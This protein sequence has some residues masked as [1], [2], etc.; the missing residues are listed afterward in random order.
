MLPNRPATLNF[1]LGEAAEMIRDSARD[2]AENDIAP[3]AAEIDRD[4]RFPRDLWP[5]MGALGL[6]G[7]TAPEEYGGLGL[8]YTLATVIFGGLTPWVAQ[9][10]VERTGMPAAPGVNVR[11]AF[12]PSAAE[13]SSAA[14]TLP[15]G[16]Y[17]V[18]AGSSVLTNSPAGPPAGV[19]VES[20]T[21]WPAPPLNEKKSTSAAPATCPSAAAR[22]SSGLA[23]A[24]DSLARSSSVALIAAC[25]T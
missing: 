4:N 16:S 15:A 12:R 18:S 11:N 25:S 8:G 17:T 14:T 20:V 13:L 2:Y 24:A 23:A 10:L 21:S 22:P 19:C 9:V 7:I 6:H 1:D 5:A 3:R